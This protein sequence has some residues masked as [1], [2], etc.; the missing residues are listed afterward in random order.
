VSPD[1]LV[2]RTLDGSTV[3]FA[4][5]ATARIRVNNKPASIAAIHQ[6]FVVVVTQRGQAPLTIDAYGPTLAR[7]HVRPLVGTIRTLT[8][9]SMVLAAAGRSSVTF[10]VDPGSRIFVDGKTSSGDRLAAGDVAVVRPAAGVARTAYEVDAFSGGRLYGGTIVSVTPTKLGVRVRPGRVLRF[11]VASLG[12]IYL[13][14]SAAGTAR[15]HA[16]LVV[17]VRTAPRHELWAFGAG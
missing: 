4:V 10:A 9:D 5:D 14:D 6:G 1:E 13:N 8:A 7:A 17:V 2:V 11:R 3:T 16:G 12:R 15:L